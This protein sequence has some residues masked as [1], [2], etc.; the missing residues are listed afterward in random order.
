MKEIK[1]NFTFNG[2]D[3]ELNAMLSD[4]INA[5]MILADHPMNEFVSAECGMADE[6]GIWNLTFEKDDLTYECDFMAIPTDDGYERLTLDPCE[7]L[8]WNKKGV[9]CHNNTIHFEVKF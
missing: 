8:V 1:I 6:L 4:D 9:S 2:N 3:V 5:G 7:V